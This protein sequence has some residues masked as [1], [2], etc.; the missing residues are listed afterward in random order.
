MA[1][2][3]EYEADEQDRKDDGSI[4]EGLDDMAVFAPADMQ[5]MAKI[6]ADF[7]DHFGVAPSNLERELIPKGNHGPNI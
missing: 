6:V 5:A 2:V 4:A 3:H 1:S 7:I